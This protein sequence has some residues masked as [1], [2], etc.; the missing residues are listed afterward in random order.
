MP[1]AEVVVSAAQY[2]AAPHLELQ[3]VATLCT[4]ST[5]DCEFGD[6]VSARQDVA[7]GTL[8]WEFAKAIRRYDSSGTRLGDLG[9]K[10]KGPGEYDIA[11]AA[12]RSEG[13][14]AVVDVAS[15]RI[16]R[17][18]SAGAFVRFD[19]LR[20]L[21]QTTRAVEF[22]DGD[23][24][25]FSVQPRSDASGSTFRAVRMKNGAPSDTIALH[26][27]P[28]YGSSAGQFQELP[29]LFSAMPT[30]DGVDGGA[31]YFT[32]GESYEI[33]EYRGGHPVRRVKVEHAPRK[34]ESEELERET[35]RRRAR[36]MPPP[37]RAAVDDAIRRAATIHPAVTQ[38]VGLSDGGLLVREAENVAG[39]SVRWTRFDRD[40]KISGYITAA[41]ASR[42]L[43]VRG[44]RMLMQEQDSAGTVLRW[45][46]VP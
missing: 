11:V 28:G 14:I 3:P 6:A 44:D 25:V 8:L 12:G 37:M 42:I 5:G 40:W 43:M 7:G 32:P 16:A 17:F 13:G 35:A 30:W 9:R 1:V 21:P 27:L 39:D 4:P 34:V 22:V 26:D 15:L 45:W 46:T 24:V 2:D 19:P 20:N 41:D 18:D 31:I 33:W 29:A 10:G 23:L 38:L 36:P